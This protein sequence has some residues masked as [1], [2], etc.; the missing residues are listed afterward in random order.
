MCT[1]YDLPATQ[2]ASA[3]VTLTSVPVAFAKV[4]VPVTVPPMKPVSVA[5]A[6]PAGAAPVP[7]AAMPDAPDA[8]IPDAPMPAAPLPAA[9]P[10]LLGNIGPTTA[11]SRQ[12]APKA[13]AAKS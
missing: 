9:A 8:P 2:F 3:T 13:S 12:P 4:A 1:G 6:L 10:A 7:A 11:V 5:T